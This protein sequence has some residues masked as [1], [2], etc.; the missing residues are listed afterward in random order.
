MCKIWGYK[1]K[2]FF[3]KNERIDFKTEKRDYD[4]QKW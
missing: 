1:G 3:I 2:Y 4:E